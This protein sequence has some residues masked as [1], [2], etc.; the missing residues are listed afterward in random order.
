MER[1]EALEAGALAIK[2]LGV[3]E[4][5]YKFVDETLEVE[6]WLAV[7]QA[8]KKALPTEDWDA[9][10]SESKEKSVDHAF[11]TK[12]DWKDHEEDTYLAK[13]NVWGAL[14]EDNNDVWLLTQMCGLG[15]AVVG[16]EWAVDHKS[17][18]FTKGNWKKYAVEANKK[19]PGLEKWKFQFDASKGTWLLPMQ[20]ESEKLADAWENDGK[21]DDFLSPIINEYMK[22]IY[23]AI[24]EFDALLKKA[25]ETKVGG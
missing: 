25:K 4:Q 3:I 5:A 24:P 2:S 12:A 1:K 11:F 14:P 23:Q 9:S 8:I 7:E 22:T 20:V 6:F 18:G 13:F 15:E 16:I 17:L 21:M 10:L 19:H